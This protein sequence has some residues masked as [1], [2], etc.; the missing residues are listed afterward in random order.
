MRQMEQEV[1][2]AALQ[3]GVERKRTLFAREAIA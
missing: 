2:R 3:W 1:I